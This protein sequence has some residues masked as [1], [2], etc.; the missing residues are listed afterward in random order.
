[1]P[2]APAPSRRF[3]W[4]KACIWLICSLRCGT[5]WIETRKRPNA[6]RSAWNSHPTMR[7]LLC[8]G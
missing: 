4:L 8:A 6:P 1:M 7:I 5:N 3:A 2:M